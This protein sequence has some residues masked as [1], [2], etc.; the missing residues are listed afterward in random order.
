MEIQLYKAG[1]VGKRLALMEMRFKCLAVAGLALAA[2]G[3]TSIT[4]F[5]SDNH[6]RNVSGRYPVEIGWESN[7]RT[8]RS[9]TLR[10][11]VLTD[12]QSSQ[13]KEHP[14]T[15]V[16]DAVNRWTALVPV[17]KGVNF[18]NYRV[19]MNFEYDKIPKPGKDS[20]LSPPYQLQVID[21]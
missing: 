9:E 16:P 19:K 14:M 5:S 3:C 4:N 6:V 20:R 2:S 8:V 17:P 10:P 13:F 1:G 15:P 21:P 18:L 11:V 7:Q 12:Y